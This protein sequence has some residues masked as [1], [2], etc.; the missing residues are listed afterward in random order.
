MNDG[1]ETYTNPFLG[2][3]IVITPDMRYHAAVMDNVEKVEK[4]VLLA[5]RLRHE[6]KGNFYPLAQ[7]IRDQVAR[8]RKDARAIQDSENREEAF[9]DL[10]RISATMSLLGKYGP[11]VEGSGGQRPARPRHEVKSVT[12]G[13]LPGHGRRT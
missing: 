9:R 5:M 11:Y 13:G 4:N 10:R 8:L 12:S 6:G 1:D 7:K 3:E 2:V